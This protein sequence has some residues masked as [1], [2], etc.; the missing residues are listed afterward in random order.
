MSGSDVAP[1]Q[2]LENQGFAASSIP[3]G[4]D[5]ATFCCLTIIQENN[6]GAN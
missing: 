3:A 2:P 4:N 5:L 1:P 6:K